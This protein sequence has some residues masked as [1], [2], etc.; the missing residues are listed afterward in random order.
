LDG[1]CNLILRDALR[2][3]KFRRECGSQFVPGD[4]TNGNKHGD[5][6]PAIASSVFRG[7]QCAYASCP[8]NTS[9]YVIEITIIY[10][11]NV[12]SI[13]NAEFHCNV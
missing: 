5:S 4:E 2:Q 12:D 1:K 9:D 10:Y 3:L 6:A 13:R 11:N 8:Q 7:L